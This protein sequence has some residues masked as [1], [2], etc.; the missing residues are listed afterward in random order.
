MDYLH[1]GGQ[2]FRYGLYSNFSPGWRVIKLSR[3]HV[4]FQKYWISFKASS[5]A[6][7]LKRKI[8]VLIYFLIRL[9]L[10]KPLRIE[11]S[12]RSFTQRFDDTESSKRCVKLLSLIFILKYIFWH[13]LYLDHR[14]PENWKRSMPSRYLVSAT[15]S[16]NH[17]CL[18]KKNFFFVALSSCYEILIWIDVNN[19]SVAF[20]EHT[21]S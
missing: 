9:N 20:V 19:D 7:K 6:R 18:E 15:E 5:S 16:P 4:F 14:L 8:F 11:I 21:I 3:L 2:S 12:E 1:L 17:A 13:Y 10:V